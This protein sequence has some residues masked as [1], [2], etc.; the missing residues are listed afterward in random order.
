[1]VYVLNFLNKDE[2]IVKTDRE[3]NLE[4]TGKLKNF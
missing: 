3:K 4:F 2:P 1:M